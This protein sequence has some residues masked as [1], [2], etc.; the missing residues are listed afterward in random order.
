MLFRK[1]SVPIEQEILLSHLSIALLHKEHF[2][3][4][5]HSP[6]IRLLIVFQFLRVLQEFAELI[7]HVF[8]QRLF[9][10]LHFELE[11]VGV[12]FKLVGAIDALP[13]EVTP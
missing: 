13:W 7:R 1:Q 2:E 4:V 11:Y 5:T 8:A 6:V 12:L 3:L 10:S 9:D